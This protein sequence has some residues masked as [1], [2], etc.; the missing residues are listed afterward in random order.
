MP[1]VWKYKELTKGKDYRGSN[2]VKKKRYM[3]VKDLQL[4]L[5]WSWFIKTIVKNSGKRATSRW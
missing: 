3:Q 2:L 1:R 4:G 5:A